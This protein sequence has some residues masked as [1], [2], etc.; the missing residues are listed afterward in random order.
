MKTYLS[1]EIFYQTEIIKQLIHLVMSDTKSCTHKLGRNV[2]L[3]LSKNSLGFHDNVTLYNEAEG[4]RM[5]L[6][7]NNPN[8]S[9][10]FT[11][12]YKNTRISHCDGEIITG[13]YTKYPV[14][15]V[16]SQSIEEEV[17]QLSTVLNNGDLN[18]ILLISEI[19]TM[20]PG[21]PHICFF[22]NTTFFSSDDYKFISEKLS[23][24]CNAS[25]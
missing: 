13:D 10:N 19:E 24:I 12:D 15:N 25:N 6:C 7:V 3:A 22:D 4:M 21:H 23:G 1:D 18:G 17:F 20:L 11:Y 14:L 5:A 2:S 8:L 9:C 16:N